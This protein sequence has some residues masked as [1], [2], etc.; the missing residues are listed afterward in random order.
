MSVC[1]FYIKER[2]ESCLVERDLGVLIDSQLNMSQQCA[3]VAK[4]ANGIRAWIRNGVVSRTSE[5]ILLCTQVPKTEHSTR[6]EAS[7]MSS[8][9]AG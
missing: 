4:K 6:G 7:P 2:Q 3:Q 5:V 1:L 9:G 8:T